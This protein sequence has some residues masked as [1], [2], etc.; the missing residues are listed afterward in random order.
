MIWNVGHDENGGYHG[1]QAGDQTGTECCVRSWFSSPWDC[2]LRYPDQALA[3]E[4]AEL[5]RQAA[6]N[7]MIGYDQYQRNTFYERLRET[8]TWQPK[9]IA[10]P[11]ETDCARACTTVW[12]A[13]GE[14]HGVDALKRLDPDPYNDT[15]YT[16]NAKARYQAAGFAVLTGDFFTGSDLHL[17]PGDCLLNEHVHMAMCVDVGADVAA[18]VWSPGSV[19]DS[20][21]DGMQV[22][23]DGTA[24]HGGLYRVQAD[25]LNVRT[26][27]SLSGQAVASYSKGETVTLDD[28][29]T[30]ADGYVWGRYTGGSGKTRYIAIGKANF[31][32]S[33]DDYLKLC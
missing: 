20:E 11:C 5:A 2:V 32:A 8:G 26:S 15:T 10:T 4:A 28:W 33:P 27:P 12:Q 24:F 18:G 9:D 16:A 30:V 7:D 1:G 23:S 21:E 14:L 13:V 17:L 3:A 29:V 19:T 6:A 25:A 22:S 31:T